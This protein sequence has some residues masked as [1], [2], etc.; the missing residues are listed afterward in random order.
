MYSFA[1]TEEEQ[2]AVLLFTQV[3][4]TCVKVFPSNPHRMSSI[5]C[6]EDITIILKKMARNPAISPLI[7][8]YIIQGEVKALCIGPI[9]NAYGELDIM[10][11]PVW[12]YLMENSIFSPFYSSLFHL[13][14]GGLRPD[15]GKIE[16]ITTA[17]LEQGAYEKEAHNAFK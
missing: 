15:F 5:I 13:T 16:K 8:E 7:R 12:D 4:L 2:D 17:I 1:R 6:G 9:L 10:Q 11:S 3:L 14:R